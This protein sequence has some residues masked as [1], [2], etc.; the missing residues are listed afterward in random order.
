MQ[1]LFSVLL[2]IPLFFLIIVYFAGWQIMS[3]DFNEFEE[4]RLQTTNNYATDAAVE[5]LLY[6]DD[7]NQDHADMKEMT[8][9]PMLARKTF[10]EVFSLSY[11]VPVTSENLDAIAAEY[12]E[13][14]VVAVYDGYYVFANEDIHHYEYKVT[15]QKD[16]KD[17][18]EWV[19][20]RSPTYECMPTV[21]IPY[22]YVVED[23]DLEDGKDDSAI[24]T[25]NLGF[26]DAVILTSSK[27]DVVDL[28]ISPAV[29]MNNINQQ[30]NL[31][32]NSRLAKKVDNGLLRAVNIPVSATTVGSA[33]NSLESVSVLAFV[34]GVNFTTSKELSSFSIGGAKIY[35]NRMVA[36]YTRDNCKYY[37][38]A[39]LI[40]RNV[41]NPGVGIN[42]W[43]DYVVNTIEEA[44]ALGYTC[45]LELMCGGA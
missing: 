38:Y 42:E 5:E 45:D 14:M 20:D 10:L 27:L 26:D 19:D 22:K 6:S 7:L 23:T 8:L 33:N 41:V 9:N 37:C 15:G 13:L 30:I 34:D 29:A 16:G 4:Y 43:A 28:P 17:T 11:D 21:K 39:D 36:C 2:V 1:R 44:A 3:A 18:W 12:L 40:N 32:I 24:Y 35:E 31:E 25:Y